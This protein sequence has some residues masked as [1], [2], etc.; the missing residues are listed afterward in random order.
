MSIS[1]V[2]VVGVRMGWDRMGWELVEGVGVKRRL[3]EGE[4]RDEK[5]DG[6]KGCTNLKRARDRMCC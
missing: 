3:R 1:P 2:G 4:M 5:R 6:C